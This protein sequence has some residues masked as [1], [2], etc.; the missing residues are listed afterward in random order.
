MVLRKLASKI[1]LPNLERDL[2]RTLSKEVSTMD[3]LAFM[4]GR[5]YSYQTKA[6]A[7]PSVFGSTSIRQA[8]AGSMG[9]TLVRVEK[10]VIGNGL[11][12]D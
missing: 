9:S 6:S 2:S 4:A 1:L 3:E 5:V 12:H 8:P 11:F 7:S 10:P